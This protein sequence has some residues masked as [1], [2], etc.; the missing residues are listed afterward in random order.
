MLKLKNYTQ[1][2]L[3]AALTHLH[4]VSEPDPVLEDLSRLMPTM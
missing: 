2:D 3:E 4:G 1:E